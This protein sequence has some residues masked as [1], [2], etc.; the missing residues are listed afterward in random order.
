MI[1]GERNS[2]KGRQKGKEMKEEEHSN[3]GGIF[4]N[5]LSLEAIFYL[6]LYLEAILAIF[7]YN[8]KYLNN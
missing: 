4:D 1:T 3:D 2:L 6:T 5:L 8:I 7:S